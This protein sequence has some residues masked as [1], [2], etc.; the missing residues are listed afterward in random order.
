[1]RITN[2]TIWIFWEKGYENAPILVKKCIDSWQKFNP[3]YKINVLDKKSVLNFIDLPEKIN[4]Q[5]EDLTIQ[6]ISNLIRLLLLNKY[7]GVWADATVYCCASLDS[8]LSEYYTSEFF[9]FRNPGPDRMFSSWFI[10]AESDHII[11]QKLCNE[12]ITFFAGNCFSNQHTD[13]GRQIISTLHP[14]LTA[15]HPSTLQWFSPIIV[16]GLK[17]YPYYIFH[18]MFNKIILHNAECRDLWMQSKPFHADILHKLQ[19]TNQVQ[20]AIDKIETNYSPLYKLNWR[21]NL[22]EHYWKQVFKK[23]DGLNYPKRSSLLQKILIRREH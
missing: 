8:W 5:R 11:L 17:I 1:M 3:N 21:V 13:F 23:L 18:Y 12:Y 15:D 2:K 16:Q 10:A 14:T 9:V 4:F 20:E 22:E 6:K 19:F 7:G